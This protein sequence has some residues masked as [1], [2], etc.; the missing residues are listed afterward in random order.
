MSKNTLF[1]FIGLHFTKDIFTSECTKVVLD[2]NKEES[3]YYRLELAPTKVELRDKS[4]AY[5]LLNHHISIYETERRD[6]PQLSQYHY[7]AYF[8]N[9]EGEV[10]RLHVYFNANDE[11]TMNASFSKEEEIG[12]TPIETPRLEDAFINL[13]ITHVRPVIAQLRKNTRKPL[14][15]WKSILQHLKKKP[16]SYYSKGKNIQKNMWVYWTIFAG[17]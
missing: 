9:A 5:K 2:R 4:Q 6:N 12:Y 14:N 13:A 15:N 1:N 17:F 10:F 3:L 7:T 8:T 11:L 16:R